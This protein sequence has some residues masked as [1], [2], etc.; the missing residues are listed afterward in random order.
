MPDQLS[1]EEA[2]LLQ[3]IEQSGAIPSA[4]RESLLRHL[5][6]TTSDA[7]EEAVER[8]EGSASGETREHPKLFDRLR[9]RRPTTLI[10]EVRQQI[11][12]RVGSYSA[13]QLEHLKAELRRLADRI[14]IQ[15][16]VQ[17]LLSQVAIDVTL[18]IKLAPQ[19]GAPLGVTPQVKTSAKLRLIPTPP[20]RDEERAPHGESR[21][22]HDDSNHDVGGE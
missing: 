19:D 20:T 22:A 1:P 11:G 14:D 4:L 8:V 21:D 10:N 13:E 9:R 16:E 7:V 15:S 3:L 18:T 17:R 6:T 5:H 12:D 2:R